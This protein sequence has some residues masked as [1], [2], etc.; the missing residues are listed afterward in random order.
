[1]KKMILLLIL[2]AHANAGWFDHGEKAE[3]ERR[4]AAEQELE[5]ERHA[6]GGW[7]IVAGIMA[8]GAVTLFVVGCAMGSKTRRDAKKS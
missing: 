2:A 6:E 1:M 7:V 3:R 4:I 8:L 5:Q